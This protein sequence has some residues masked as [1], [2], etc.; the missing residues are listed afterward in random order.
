MK[1]IYVKSEHYR[2]FTNENNTDRLCKGLKIFTYG[3][4]VELL[5]T[6]NPIVEKIFNSNIETEYFLEISDPFRK[7]ITFN[8][9][10]GNSYRLDINIIPEFGKVCNHISFSIN[11]PK[12]DIVPQTEEEYLQLDLEYSRVTGRGEMIEILNRIR[13]VLNDIIEKKIISNYF[14]IGISEIES[15]NKIYEYFLDI[16]VG[17]GGF[18]KLKTD[19]YPKSGYG[20]YFKI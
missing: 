17:D 10:A 5:K 19:I 11:D 2:L 14:C 9:T 13:Y 15:K 6:N 7:K 8:S 4:K 1:Y 20:L 18:K 16:V 3:E 12:F